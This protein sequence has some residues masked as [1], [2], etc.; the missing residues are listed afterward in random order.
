MKKTFMVLLLVAIAIPGWTQIARELKSKA[1]VQNKTENKDDL[2]KDYYELSRKS[3]LLERGQPTVYAGKSL[4]AIQ[5][6]VGGI[7]TG[8]IQYDGNAVPRFWQIFNNMTHDFVPNSFFAVRVK[9]KNGVQVRALQTKDVVGFK[10][11]KALEASSQFPFI[12]YDF[13]D[14]LP[15]NISMDVFNPFIPTD[16]KNSE[17]PAVFYRFSISNTGD[18]AIEVSLLASQQN[19]VGFTQVEKINR[20]IS[21]AD[22]YQASINRTLVSGN[23]SSFYGGNTNTVKAEENAKVLLMEGGYDKADE[24]YGQMALVALNNEAEIQGAAAWTSSKRLASYFKKTGNIKEKTEIAASKKGMTW[25]GALNLKLTVLPGETKHLNMILTWYFPNGLNGG[26]MD[27]WDAWGKGDWEGQGNNYANYWSNINEVNDYIIKNHKWLMQTSEKFAD[28]YYQTNFPWW[29]TERLGNQLAILKSRTIFHDKRGYVGLWE[30]CGS[31]DGSCSGNCNHVWHYAQSHARLFPEM[32][33]RIKEQSFEAIKE[34]GQ[35]PYRQPAGSP[36]FDGQCG[37]IIG[38]YREYLLSADKAWL[39]GQYPAIKKAMNYLVNK[40][41]TDKDGWLSDAPKH[42][43]YDASMTGNP[44][45]LTSLY[46]VALKA[47]AEMAKVAGDNEQAASWEK[48]SVNSIKLQDDHLWNGEYYYQIPGE[49]RATDYENGC[50]TDQ[51][52]GQWWADQLNMGSLYPDYRIHEATKAVL[53]YNFKSNLKNHIQ[54]SRKFAKD[55]EA[56]MV[57]T[58]WPGNDRTPYASGYSD[59]VWTSYEYTIGAALMKYGESRGAATLLRSGYDRYNGVLREG[60]KTDNGWG[61]FGYS[62]NP[63]GDDECGQFYSRALASWS[64]LL[65]AQGF[66]Y[67]GPEGSIAFNPVWKPEAHTSFF[68]TAKGWGTFKQTNKGGSLNNKL[69]LAH[70]T[71]VLKEIA[72]PALEAEA[73]KVSVMLN[74]QKI[75]CKHLVKDHQLLVQM[76]EKQ[77]K[78]GDVLKIEQVK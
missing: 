52:L 3:Y 6:P 51:L 14:E 65:A 16:L 30:G 74:G 13:K 12:T 56:G 53:K 43:T 46:A 61:N 55:E 5:F 49:K 42:T 73:A 62:G 76:D 1:S 60:Y 63:F 19:A 22:N 23:S 25:S 47:S 35:I 24:H 77:L 39:K 36:A 75:A 27:K 17:I 38:A 69:E 78:A 18:E 10:G 57:G 8:C 2:L 70:G 66:E 29:L 28:A 15:A 37:D 48:M 41:D 45:I 72:V 54:V 33:R 68:S 20:N 71:L 9:S 32:G 64:V 11:M 31:G 21:F 26:H 50:M 44:S 67:N 58:T 34:N 59:E 4:E 7:G 40:H